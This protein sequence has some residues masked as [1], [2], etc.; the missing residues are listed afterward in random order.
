[1]NCKRF[2]CSSNQVL[3]V[4]PLGLAF[5]QKQRIKIKR[6]LLLIEFNRKPLNDEND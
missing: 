4:L 5:V 2:Y 6:T 3:K 1:M